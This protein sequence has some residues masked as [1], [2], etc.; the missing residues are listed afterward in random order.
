[1]HVFLLFPQ[2]PH[3]RTLF[4][5]KESSREGLAIALMVN[6]VNIVE[7]TKTLQPDGPKNIIE[8]IAETLCELEDNGFDINVLRDRVVQLLL[9]RK[10]GEELEA[11]E[12]E[13]KYNIKEENFE[14]FYNHIQRKEL[15]L[16]LSTKAPN[17]SIVAR[18]E[19]T[20]NDIND[21]I[22]NLD[23]EFKAIVGAP[24]KVG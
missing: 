4:S 12:K 5:K 17:D 6:F 18:R 22:R 19:R 24:W 8:D 11:K 15:A 14:G 7:K 21:S 9:I 20:V 3:F 23:L 16:D 1:M 13:V 2:N 10:K